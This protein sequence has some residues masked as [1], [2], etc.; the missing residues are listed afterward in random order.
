MNPPLQFASPEWIDR[1][2][3][4][5][6]ELVAEH[7]EN[8]ADADFTVSETYTDVPP[9]GITTHFSARIRSGE[10]TFPDHPDRTDFMLVG[11]YEAILPGARLSFADASQS[12]WDAAKIHG[13][14]MMSAGHVFIR[15]G[16]NGASEVLQ[17]VLRTVHDTMARESA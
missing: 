13:T 15:G 10:V 3:V 7:R 6:A 8:L 16:T 4:V 17:R 1:I 9:D 5:F 14:A 11:T 12:E 2:K